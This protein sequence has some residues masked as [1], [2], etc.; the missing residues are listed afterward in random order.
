VKGLD[1]VSFYNGRLTVKEVRSREG[2]AR[3]RE[4]ACLRGIGKGKGK[5]KSGV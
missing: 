5:W 3:S 4:A 2:D 1:G